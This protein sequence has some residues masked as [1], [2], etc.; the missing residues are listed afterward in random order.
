M[1]TDIAEKKLRNAQDAERDFGEVLTSFDSGDI[2]AL[3]KLCNAINVLAEFYDENPSSE[4]A[5][6]VP[7]LLSYL[8]GK[9]GDS[10]VLV[11]RRSGR[12]WGYSPRYITKFVRGEHLHGAS[13]NL[14]EKRRALHDFVFEKDLTIENEFQVSW[15]WIVGPN[16]RAQSGNKDTDG[17][18]VHAITLNGRR[19]EVSLIESVIFAIAYEFWQANTNGAPEQSTKCFVEFDPFEFPNV[20]DQELAAKIQG[21]LD[22]YRVSNST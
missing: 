18:F 14:D 5:E 8:R 12:S 7:K 13:E 16:L 3:G 2:D 9:F 19:I 22:M 10:I 11:L 4:Y 17:A 15:N 6:R 21:S 1:K 20:F